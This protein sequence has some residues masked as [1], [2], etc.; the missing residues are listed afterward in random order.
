MT[1]TTARGV[2]APPQRVQSHMMLTAR[3]RSRTGSQW[4]KALARL[5]K[6]PASPA[7]KRNCVTRSEARFQTRPVAAVKR[8]QRSTTRI[9]TL[10][11][12]IRS[13]SQ[14]PGISKSA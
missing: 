1:H 8:D 9:S 11:G 5:G 2:M 12:P 7:P 4:V 6:A 10:R 14:P 3:F 13:P